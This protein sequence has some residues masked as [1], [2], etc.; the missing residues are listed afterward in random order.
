MSLVT[1][2]GGDGLVECHGRGMVAAVVRVAMEHGRA[3]RRL[4]HSRMPAHV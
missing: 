1:P 2:D 4:G 3:V